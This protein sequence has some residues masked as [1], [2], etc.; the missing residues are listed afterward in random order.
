MATASWDKTARVWDVVSG[1]AVTPPLA[2]KGE[3]TAVAWSPDGKRVA[4][5]SGDR[6]ARVWDFKR[7]CA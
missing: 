4:T 6:T 3:V 1:Q 7:G 5:A 2:H